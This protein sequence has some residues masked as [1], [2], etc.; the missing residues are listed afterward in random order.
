MSTEEICDEHLSNQQEERQ[1]IRR[2]HALARICVLLVVVTVCGVIANLFMAHSPSTD[3]AVRGAL[4][5]T[6]GSVSTLGVRK[7]LPAIF[8]IGSR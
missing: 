5:T 2:W 7:F 8:S 4:L 1:E 6:L 3:D